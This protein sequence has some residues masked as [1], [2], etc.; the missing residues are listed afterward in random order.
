MHDLFV[1]GG[2]APRGTENVCGE[3]APLPPGP[4]PVATPLSA[5]RDSIIDKARWTHPLDNATLRHEIF[6]RI[7]CQAGFQTL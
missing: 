3:R 2:G 4:P 1:W 5:G 6:A 7:I